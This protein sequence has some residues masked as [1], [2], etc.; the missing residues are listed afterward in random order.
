MTEGAAVSFLSVPEATAQAQHL[1]DEDVAE[2]GYVMNVSRAWAYEPGILTELFDLMRQAT[3]P[4]G[5]DVRQRGILV[6]ACASTVGDSYCA[7]S[8]GSKLA[9]ATD[10]DTAAGVL[11]GDDDGLTSSE[12]A[13]ASWARKVARDPNGTSRSDVQALRDAGYG[14]AQIFA[15]TVYVALRLAFSTVNDALG[16]SPDAALRHTAPVAVLDAVTFGRP[17]EAVSKAGSPSP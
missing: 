13:M 6:A 1:F 17:I 12:R 3:S 16:V 9:E 7:L 14:D 10:A 4:H 15:I 5:L 8:W 2:V 11:R